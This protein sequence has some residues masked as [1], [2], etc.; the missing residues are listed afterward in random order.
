MTIFL[1]AHKVR[2]KAAFDIAERCEDMGTPLD[3]GPWWIISTSGHRAR[4]YWHEP[5][6]T[7]APAMPD[8]L[9]DHYPAATPP[10]RKAAPPPVPTLESLA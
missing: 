4:P 9:P 3:P 1:I 10:R 7:A 2:G 8:D 5:L 6:L